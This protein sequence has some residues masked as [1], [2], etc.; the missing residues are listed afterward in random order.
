M[1]YREAELREV[2]PSGVP[3]DDPARFLRELR[4]LRNGAGLEHVELAARAHYPCDA[5]LAAEAGPALPD[6][7]VLSA[8]VRGCGGTV[9]DWEERWRTLTRSPALTL[10]P[11]RDAGGSDAA[12]AGARIGSVSLAADAHDPAI[13]MA[14]LGRVANG[15]APEPAPARSLFTPASA[16]K[17]AASAPPVLE[18][19]SVF[20]AAPAASSAP[21]AAPAAS[22]APFASSAPAVSSKPRSL[23]PDPPDVAGATAAPGA[24]RV[25]GGAG[26]QGRALSAVKP[27]STAGRAPNARRPVVSKPLI[28]AVV[29]LVCLAAIIW[30]LFS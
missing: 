2:V 5:I 13:I 14:A 17:V 6:L 21:A 28:V 20:A 25:P 7:P 3:D 22:S 16:A 10:L 19:A 26:T 18:Q 12:A 11:T 24:A 8:Y 30:A 23:T 27:A 4:Q 15:I 9:T 29:I 1:E